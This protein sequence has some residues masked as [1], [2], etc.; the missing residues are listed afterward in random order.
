MASRINKQFGGTYD[1]Y[2]TN[3]HC[4]YSNNWFYGV[5]GT[6]EFVIELCDSL[7]IPPGDQIQGIVE[8]NLPGPFYLLDRLSGPGLT[9]HITDAQTDLPLSAEVEVLEATFPVLTPRTSD[10]EYGR[11]FRILEP[12]NYTMRVGKEGYGCE[13]RDVTDGPDTLTT[14][15]FE[16]YANQAPSQFSLLSP[17][18]EDTVL[19]PTSFEWELSTDPDFGEEVSYDILISLSPNFHFD[20]IMTV[21]NVQQSQCILDSLIFKGFHR[22]FWKVRAHDDFCGNTWSNQ[23]FSFFAFNCGDVNKDGVIDIADV[24]YLINYL[25]IEGPAPDPLAAGDANSDGVVDIAD[26]V[27]L[28]NYLFIGG[29]PP[30]C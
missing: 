15:D 18:D 21:Y 11:Y 10:P 19:I 2:Q 5:N 17:T 16:L 25:F 28:I 13:F 6:Y 24:L 22:Y 14:E 7:T 30:C 23:T 27:Y 9:G 8:D 1:V 20:S 26:V 3:A 12:G 29:S 4:G